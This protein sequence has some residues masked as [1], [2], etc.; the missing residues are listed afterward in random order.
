MVSLK[1][2]SIEDRETLIQEAR[3]IVEKENLK[4]DAKTM[5]S[6]KKRQLTEETLEEISRT[7]HLKYD[8]EKRKLKE[9][10]VS[11]TNFMYKSNVFK[12]LR[13][14]E[15]IVI[16]TEE[17]WKTYVQ[18]I[19]NVKIMMIASYNGQEIEVKS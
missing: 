9:R 19:N 14:S 5:Y 7:F 2:L 17:Q 16:T 4:R 12:N 10:L 3:E 1:D 18:I 15:N 8:V 13:C 6:L 11:L